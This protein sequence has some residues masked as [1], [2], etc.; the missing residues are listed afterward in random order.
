MAS[1]TSTPAALRLL[2]LSV[3][4]QLPL[5][6]FSIMLLLQTQHLTGS[7]AAGGVV[8][9]VYAMSVGAG[10]PVLGRLSDRHGQTAVLIASAAVAATAL[11]A[12]A[13]V[14]A[15]TSAAVIV[16]LA[17]TA[18]VATPPVGACTRTL[19][20]AVLPDR[21]AVQSAYAAEATASELAWVCGPPLALAVGALISDGAALAF[22]AVILVGATFGLAAQPASRRWRPAVTLGPR[23]GGSLRVAAMRTLVLI[24]VAIGVLFG[25][26]EVGVTGAAEQLGTT[27]IAAPLLALW[28]AGSLTGGVLVTRF[29]TQ[30]NSG[31]ELMRLL[32][33]LVVGHAALAVAAGSAYTLGALLFVAGTAIAPT[34]STVYAIV[35]R[36]APAS[37]LTEAFAWLETAVAVGGAI[38]AAVAGAL[39]QAAGPPTVFAFAGAMGLAALLAATRLRARD[40]GTSAV[41][42]MDAPCHGQPAT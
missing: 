2:G 27:N 37:T 11:C 22:G 18:G 34:Y 19:F 40:P 5:T 31:R 23:R 6:T 13:L 33:A 35:D 12:T 32:A 4:G 9:G 3:L 21:R 8:T 36:V 30:Q 42:A 25:A 15:G 26:A 24:L 38:G 28:G 1:I 41:S 7:F 17:A 16:V 29:G 14:P 20:A 10:G 39:V